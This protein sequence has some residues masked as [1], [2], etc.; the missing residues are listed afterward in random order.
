M[1]LS[2][3]EWFGEWTKKFCTNGSFIVGNFWTKALSSDA[4]DFFFLADLISRFKNF[5]F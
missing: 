4:F 1:I 3:A 2:E 5:P